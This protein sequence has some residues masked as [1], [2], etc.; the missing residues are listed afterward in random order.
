MNFKYCNDLF[1]YSRFLTRVVNVGDVPLGGSYPIRIQS[2][3]NTPTLDTT[4]T[5][6]QC[7]R[8]ANAGADYVRITTQSIREAENLAN[9]KSELRKKGYKI[10]IIA[11][12]HFNPE[13]AE[14]AASLVEKVRINPGN[15]CDKK[16]IGKIEFSEKEY[17]EE[18]DKIHKRLLSLLN[19]C[20]KNG[21]A[22]R[23]GVNH[24]SLSDRIMDRYGDTPE[25]MVESAME[26]LRICNSE[27]FKNIVVSLKSSNTRVMIQANRLLVHKMMNERMNY[28]L[29]LGV[30]EAGE[31]ETGRI[32]SSVGIG[33]LLAD[34]LGDTIRV[35]LTEDPEKE[36][37]VAKELVAYF[38]NRKE[39]LKIP[40]PKTQS[41]NPFEFRRPETFSIENIGDK[42]VPIVITDWD[43][44]LKEIETISPLPEYYYLKSGKDFSD[45]PDNFRYI[46]NMHDWF[47]YARDNKNIFP[48]YTDA[49]FCYYGTKHPF[50]NF[51]IISNMDNLPKLF[52]AIEQHK[53]V[54]LIIETL[55]TNGVADQ[56]SLLYQL[57][58]RYIKNPV[59]INRNYSENSLTTL[60]IKSASDIG[61]L[62]ADGFSNGI[63]IRN[64]GTIQS[65][66]IIS[67]SFDILQAGR[68][69]TTKTE[70]ISCPSCGRTLFDIQSVL[71]GVKKRTGHLKNLKIAVMGCMVNGLGEMADADY[72]Y[73]GAGAGKVNL[74]K[75]KQVIKKNIP[76]AQAIEELIQVIKDNGDWSLDS[77]SASS[78]LAAQDDAKSY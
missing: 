25:G 53:N 74:Y 56:R 34:G 16:R 60:Q 38:S 13:I 29:H 43:E 77:P 31:G 37:P 76:S 11:D 2:M 44:K 27:N 9:I 21:T 78:G 7:I 30:T 8:I 4:A 52:E 62:L 18:L 22:L 71:A 10:P 68:V 65:S 5:V 33:S 51:V 73:V 64:E 49:Q 14:I 54:I 35:S 61:A 72:G 58:E 48:F 50:L 42:N 3:T 26:F 47:K 57:H 40:V 69:R 19:I 39:N 36:I 32:K 45:L 17:K 75:G 67:T 46:L 59:I 70:F 15:Y 1:S 12:V 6:Q 41:V 66:D 24:G 23:I 55:N 20:K 63:W 28:P